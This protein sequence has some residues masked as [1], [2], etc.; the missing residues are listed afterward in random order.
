MAAGDRSAAKGWPGSA[1]SVVATRGL[2]ESST[3]SFEMKPVVSQRYTTPSGRSAKAA[4]RSATP[5]FCPTY[6]YRN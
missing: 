3:E 2:R 4:Y 5:A 6:L 1:R